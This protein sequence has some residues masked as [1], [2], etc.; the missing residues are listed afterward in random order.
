MES[1][2]AEAVAGE[3]KAVTS[4]RFRYGEKTGC[5]EPIRDEAETGKTVSGERNGK[6]H[7]APETQCSVRLHARSEQGWKSGHL[8]PF[9]FGTQRWGA[10]PHKKPEIVYAR[11]APSL[12]NR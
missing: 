12:T 9:P 2:K 8:E 1:A 11:S 10:E 4:E 7:G 5:G 6:A 3:G